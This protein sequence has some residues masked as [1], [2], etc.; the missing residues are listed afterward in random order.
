MKRLRKYLPLIP[1]VLILVLVAA[2]IGVWRDYRDTLMKNQEEELLLVTRILRDNLRVSMEEYQDN[3]EFV[4]GILAADTQ[5]EENVYRRF[6][7]THNNFISNLYREDARGNI[8]S[9]AAETDFSTSVLLAEYTDEKSIWMMSDGT[10]QYIVFKKEED[11]GEQICLAVDAEKYYRQLISDIRIG[12]NGYIVVKNKEGTVIMHPDKAQWGQE[13]IEG[14][15]ERFPDLDYSSLEAML[16]EQ[17]EGK[18][19][20]SRYYSYWW[21]KPKVQKTEKISAYCSAEMGQDAWIVSAVIDYDDFYAPIAEGFLKISLI[22]TTGLVLVGV[23]VLIYGRMLRIVHKSSREIKNLKELNAL[24]ENVQKSEDAIAHQERL[25]IMGTMTGGIAHEFN[26]FLTP[27][28]GHAELLMM[29]LP[30]GSDEQDSAKEIYEASEKA[31][32]VVK[33]ISSLSRKNVETVYKC[34]PVKK[35]MQR[36]LKMIT[37]VCPPQVHLESELHVEQE[38]ILGNTTQLNQVLLNICVNA[39]HAIGKKEGTI[40]VK[41]EVISRE[42]LAGS[43]DKTLPDTWT[44]YIYISIRDNGCGMEKETLRQ[45]FDPFFTTKKGGEGTGLGLALVEQIV[46]SHKGYVFAES[47]PGEGSCFH[48]GLPVLQADQP[49][50]IV[51][52]G[53]RYEIRMVFADDNA[54]ILELLH[55]SFSKI[56]MQIQTCMTIEE[57]T[58]KLAEKEADVLVIEENVE[59]Q[60]GVD[61]CMSIAGKYP[62]MLK[63]I[64]TDNISREIMEAKKK[65]IIN[66][67]VEKP[68]SDRNVLE[69]VRECR[70]EKG[71]Y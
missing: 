42:T 68:L 40:Q 22:F 65:G 28:M 27:I 2:G 47:Q 63:L 6:L 29:E 7:K 5:E 59:G 64:S 23:L 66:G 30:E 36:A 69:A 32:D 52:A 71:V 21:T 25:Q 44:E 39:I 61:F 53:E 60:N 70:K 15:K 58:E 54:K 9:S 1:A 34:I 45:I 48:V 38:N 14:R 37:S 13:V 51:Q 4:S 17:S 41:C 11:S 19:G 46:T 20:I 67:Y 12:T 62:K 24:L 35:M 3:L 26:N 33:Q 31:M 57:L 49:E 50:E 43:L 55:R 16:K 8:I 18:E 10:D 56:G